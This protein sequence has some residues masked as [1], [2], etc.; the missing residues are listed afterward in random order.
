MEV[1][2]PQTSNFLTKLSHERE[3]ALEADVGPQ[4]TKIEFL[5]DFW[6][7][8]NTLTSK[9]VLKE[10]CS[11]DRSGESLYLGD[12][13]AE[14]VPF[15]TRSLQ[16]HLRFGLS[17]VQEH[18]LLKV[19]KMNIVQL[20][21][22][23]KK[24][25][26]ALV[27]FLFPKDDLSV[28]ELVIGGIDHS[29]HRGA[30][31][32]IPFY[33]SEGPLGSEKGDMIVV[34]LDEI[35]LNG[36][37]LAKGDYDME[38]STSQWTRLPQHFLTAIARRFGGVYDEVADFYYFGPSIATT[39]E[40]LTLSLDGAKVNVPVRD[41]V[42][43]S[44]LETYYLSLRPSIVD[45]VGVLGMDILKYAY[46]V[47]DYDNREIG[48]ASTFRPGYE[49]SEGP[50]QENAFC[51]PMTTDNTEDCSTQNVNSMVTHCVEEDA[52]ITVF[53][54]GAVLD[55]MYIKKREYLSRIEKRKT[56][57]RYRTKTKTKTKASTSL[58]RSSLLASLNVKVEIFGVN[59]FTFYVGCACVTFFIL[60]A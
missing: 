25:K 46:I 58:S 17:E 6:G 23:Q 51:V 28:G 13:Q 41:L 1:Y 16:N 3:L 44:G 2:E 49:P 31:S 19:D 34:V 26:S 14:D 22:Y 56:K 54:D 11:S 15:T 45:D 48:F 4:K 36:Q 5:V 24:I 47:I 27:S 8:S 59:I 57:H 33:N 55:A 40:I 35:L 53:P 32:K 9:S 39:D 50:D 30:L 20:L 42:T 12:V 21:K 18:E 29:K 60:V 37:Q 52:V 43:Q 7:Y 10:D 38:V